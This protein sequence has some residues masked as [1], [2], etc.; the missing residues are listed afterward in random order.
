MTLPACTFM[1]KVRKIILCLGE[2]KTSQLIAHFPALASQVGSQIQMVLI[3]DGEQPG[4]DF[5]L[6]ST[7]Q[8]GTEH[9]KS[10]DK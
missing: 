5:C 2:K 8:Q 6:F 3:G 4:V 9:T 7:E 1:Y 10:E